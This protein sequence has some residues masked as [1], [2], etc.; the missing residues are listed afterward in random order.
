VKETQGLIR[1]MFEADSGDREGSLDTARICARLTDPSMLPP[2]DQSADEMLPENFQSVGSRGIEILSS[3]MVIALYP[4]DFPFFEL[5]PSVE[6]GYA[7]QDDP[8]AY[9]TILDGLHLYELAGMSFIENG[10]DSDARSSFRRQRFRTAMRQSIRQVL[11]TGDSL[12]LMHDD[13]R[14][15]VYRRDHYVTRRDSTG[16]V[17]Y[18][19]TRERLDPLSLKDKQLEMCGLRRDQLETRRLCDREIDLFT[20]CEWN[21]RSNK[22]VIDQELNGVVFNTV[23][24]KVTPYVSTCYKLSPGENYGR[25]FIELNLGDLRSLDAVCEKLLDFAAMA[26]KF[27]LFIDGMSELKPKDFAK[28]TGSTVYGG[29]VKGGMLEDA[30]FF[31]ADKLADFKVVHETANRLRNDLGSAMLIQSEATPQK[32]RVTAEQVRQ[33]RDELNGALGGIYANIEDDQQAPRVDRALHVISAKKK[34]LPP[35]PKDAVQMR[36]ATGV[37]ALSRYAKAD[38]VELF[39]ARLAQLGPEALEAIDKP[40]LIS[41]MARYRNI[42]EPGLVKS[43]E[44]MRAETQQRIQDQLKLA[45]GEQAIQSAGTIA[46]DAAAQ[47]NA[48]AA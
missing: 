27:L 15:T 34:L 31:K 37:S 22:W 17:V 20:K 19:I 48:P 4:T 6:V 26:S 32:E 5:L 46:E 28:P 41:T 36:T 14:V 29:R 9:Q 8:E 38:N 45:A 35:L 12:E 3:K 44:Q 47:A 16:E 30:A 18:H 33:I 23:V 1:G 24:E 11:I 21:Y 39:V 7:V 2:D 25:G 40:T 10:I 42:N 13:G 43:R